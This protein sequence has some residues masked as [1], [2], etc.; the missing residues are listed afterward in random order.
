[1]Q[2][3]D[4]VSFSVA[5]GETVAMVGESGC[6]K[7]TLARSIVHL[8]RPD[9]GTIRLL[10][11]DVQ[12]LSDS[13]FRP[14][15]RHVQM[16]FQNPLGSFDPFYSIGH[17]IAEVAKLRPDGGSLDARLWRP[18]QRGRTES[19]VREAQGASNE[20]WRTATGGDRPR[21]GP[22]ARIGSHGRADFCA[23][24][25]DPGPGPA[26]DARPAGSGTSSVISSRRTTCARS[27]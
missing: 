12:D 25:V 18:A 21:A 13:G 5:A 7:T 14:Y 2:A 9:A 6:G 8:H 10:G 11:R 27:V 22:P 1:M 26:A 23:R 24:H 16:V 20:W 19:A 15:R 17:S 4:G 3:V